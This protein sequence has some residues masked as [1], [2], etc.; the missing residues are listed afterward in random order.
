MLVNVRAYGN[1][2]VLLR[3]GFYKVIVSKK[4]ILSTTATIKYIFIG[5]SRMKQLRLSKNKLVYLHNSLIERAQLGTTGPLYFANLRKQHDNQFWFEKFTY[6]A[7]SLSRQ[8]LYIAV[9]L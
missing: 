2:A 9:L 7:Q 6:K 8:I 5:H 1:I 3:Q 4:V